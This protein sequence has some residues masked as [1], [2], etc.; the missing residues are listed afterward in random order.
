MFRW[1]KIPEKDCPKIISDISDDKLYTFIVQNWKFEKVDRKIL[2]DG[3]I[4]K[5]SDAAPNAA[6][7]GKIKAVWPARKSGEGFYH[8]LSFKNFIDNNVPCTLMHKVK[9]EWA[10][11]VDTVVCFMTGDTLDVFLV[12][13]Y[14]L[15]IWDPNE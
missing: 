11:E 8:Y 7:A 4:F 1:S 12:H 2:K 10:P 6:H 5:I 14:D 13:P 9:N 15:K 3:S